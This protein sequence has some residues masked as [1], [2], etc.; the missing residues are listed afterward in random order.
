MMMR[1]TWGWILVASWKTHAG[2]EVSRKK[3]LGSDYRDSPV[4]VTPSN[5][6]FVHVRTCDSPS[7]G[8]AR[9]ENEKESEKMEKKRR[10]LLPRAGRA[11]HE[12]LRDADWSGET[13]HRLGDG[14]GANASPNGGADA[15]TSPLGTY[16]LRSE[17]Q[18]SARCGS[19]LP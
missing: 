15:V 12:R 16:M 7:E 11:D 1:M 14:R 4:T 13:G 6:Y 10:N 9:E 3:R 8:G 5:R 18:Q 2:R 19:I 17:F